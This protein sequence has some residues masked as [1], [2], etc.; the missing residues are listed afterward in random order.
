MTMKRKVAFKTLGCRLNQSESDSLMTDFSGAG[1]EIVDFGSNADVYIINTCTVTGQSD[2]KSKNYINQACRRKGSRIVVVT[3]CMVKS[4]AEY[5]AKRND[6]EYIVGNRTKSS[7]FQLADNHLNGNPSGAGDLKAD[8]FGFTPAE[9]GYHTRGFVK[10]ND[11]C[12]NSCSYCIVPYVRGRAVSRPLK[13][14]IDNIEKLIIAGYKEIVLTGVNIS[15]YS[16]DGSN[17]DDLVEMVLKIPGDFR[18]R[19]SSVEPEGFGDKFIKLFDDP[20]LCPH[21]HLCLQS[22]SDNILSKMHRVYSKADYLNIVEKFK[23]RCPSINLT[24]D[25][26]VGFPG[27]TDEDFLETCKMA[28]NIGFSHIHTFKYSVR[29]GTDAVNLPDHVPEDIKHE[30]SKIIRRLS[31]N[32]K[33]AYRRSLI[34]KTQRVLIERITPG[35]LASGYGECYVPVRFKNSAFMRNTLVTVHITGIDNEKSMIL[36]GEAK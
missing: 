32:N 28:E 33:L 22:G 14:I 26:I 3:G 36:E 12:N 1:Y 2:H 35:G 10:I 5:L 21:L 9:K 11:G 8:L 20:K 7:L 23:S 18:V 29:R 31:D 19:I 24:T 34:N 15:C 30:R 4:Q 13:D 17:F 6:I 27:E 25:I 16:Y